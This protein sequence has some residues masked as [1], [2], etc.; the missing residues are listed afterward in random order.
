MKVLY[1]IF[2][3]IFAMLTLISCSEQL[4]QSKASELATGRWASVDGKAIVL[5]DVPKGIFKLLQVS[6]NVPSL[7]IDAENLQVES[8]DKE[9]HQVLLSYDFNG[10]HPKMILRI[11]WQ[12][13]NRF[14]LALVNT[15]TGVETLLRFVSDSPSLNM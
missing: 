8:E 6:N 4:V 13:D 11:K 14:N 10:Q 5:V 15:L 12:E 9:P 3:V 7:I 2:L 1:K